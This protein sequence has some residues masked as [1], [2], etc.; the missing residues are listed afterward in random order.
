M[1]RDKIDGGGERIARLEVP[2]LLPGVPDGDGCMER[3]VQLLDGRPGIRSVHVVPTDAHPHDA[4]QPPGQSRPTSLREASLCLHYDPERMT[5]TQVE[6]LVRSVGAELLDRYDHAVWAIRAIG[7]EDEGARLEAAARAIDG[8][9]AA[10]VNL[11]GQVM[12]IE[13]ERDRV[14][15][16]ALGQL[17]STLQV[18]PAV[19]AADRGV[20]APSR[21][22]PSAARVQ[23]KVEPPPTWYE[24]NEEL[25]WSLVAGALLALGWWF[26]RASGRG[27][28][29]IALY[30]GSYFYGARD[31][32]AHA[33]QDLRRGTAA[34]NIDLLMI[35]AAVG[36]AS[37][38]AWSE[39]ALLL[40]LFSLGHALEHYALGRARRAIS[41]LSEL[42]PQTALVR[43]EDGTEVEM[44]IADVR[45]G[46]HVVV[47][48]AQRVS[49]DGTVVEGR[50]AVNQAPITG[51]S[52]PVAK[53]PADDV[54]AGTVNGDGALV[55][56]VTA[57]VGDRTLDR[58]I[59][60][61]AEAT[62][63]KAPTQQLTERFERVFVP[64]VLI[65]AALLAVVPPLTGLGTWNESFYRAMAVLV[66]SSPCALALGTPAAILAGIAQAARHGVLIKG[67]AHL[68]TLGTIGVL[69]IDKTGTVTVGEPSVTD[70]VPAASVTPDELLATAAAVERRSQ[71]PLAAAVVRAAEAR[72]LP[73][74]AAD[75]LESISGRGVRARLGDSIVEVGRA[76]LFEDAGVTVPANVAA[77]VTRLDESGRSTMIV[78][79]SPATTKGPGEDGGRWLGV[80]GVMDAP[81]PMVRETLDRIRA[82]GVRRIVIL[83]GDNLG[84]AQAMGRAIGIDEVRA[85]LLPE[86]KLAAI[87]ELT[88]TAK[89]AMVGDGVNDAPA[90]AHATVG[91]AMGGAGTA[92]ALETADVVLMGDQLERLPFIIGLSRRTRGVIVQNVV[93]SLGVIVALAVATA[94]GAASIAVAIAAHE[95]S[96]LLVLANALRLLWQVKETG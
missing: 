25:S 11:P 87:R 50:S 19:P 22:A 2:V 32:V 57:A 3:L 15:R 59:K 92:A 44:P 33:L 29:T 13:F 14:D 6:A 17:M 35:V 94:T 93:I 73:S 24:R 47:L 49:V 43:L 58:V 18:V 86:D 34:F 39:G 27:M 63:Q 52:A 8:V 65:V 45:P 51:E 68:E 1:K 84:V 77:E 69:A 30:L 26:E 40:V 37:I 82:A 23:G 36:A 31:T 80:I 42:S 88:A 83:T 70:V 60:L 53:G 95:G 38:G 75:D 71:H 78:R 5:L 20:A 85:N 64:V 55:I 56:A 12:R 7:A 67:G 10:S 54:F 48:P 96:T 21:A 28:V 81:R 90:L 41:A 72:A 89:V 79:Q 4:S 46:A 74:W 76:L 62:T 61:V 66:A 91:I 9:T 16:V